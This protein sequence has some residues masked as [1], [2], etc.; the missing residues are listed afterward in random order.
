MSVS[1]GKWDDLEG[2]DEEDVGQLLIGKK[3]DMSTLDS[4]ARGLRSERK[5]QVQIVKSL[6]SALGGFEEADIGRKSLLQEFHKS[7]KKSLKHKEQRDSVNRCVPP[8]SEI[9]FEWLSDTHSRLTTVDNDL[10]SVP[11]LNRELDA[12]RRFF[13]I[14][15]SIKQKILAED[16]HKMY[17]S[18]VRK[19]KEISR[20]LDE[21]REEAG[22]IVA[23]AKSENNPKGTRISRKEI[24]NI[25]NRISEIDRRLDRLKSEKAIT[26]KEINR[27]ESYTRIA[28]NR[29]G[30]VK[31][32]DIMGIAASGGS[33]S[34]EEMGAL[35]ES[36]GLSTLEENIVPGEEKEVI[37]SGK[38]RKKAR[39][40][41]VARTGGRKGRMASGRE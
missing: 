12:F 8:P 14:Q 30:R 21:N 7:R 3:R 31:L 25:S 36:G 23:E 26:R 34:K 5:D 41:G 24:R 17:A 2:M 20:K 28:S 19:L 11:M 29:P 4:E 38:I 18:E 9:L 39:K 27:I 22:K 6:R 40:L 15:A 37:K 16:A 13:E 32:S 1:K 10:T 33:L 35:L